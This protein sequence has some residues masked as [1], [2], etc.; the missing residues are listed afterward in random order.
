MGRINICH[1]LERSHLEIQRR[2]RG[3]SIPL[4]TTAILRRVGV[5]L[6]E[7]QP[8]GAFDCRANQK[9]DQLLPGA[10]SIPSSHR[11]PS[12]SL[13]RDSPD[14]RTGCH[15]GGIQFS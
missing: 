4:S 3:E 8:G 2:S 1:H 13:G 6:Q 9:G 14:G 11:I 12:L 10:L 7:P 15:R 5:L